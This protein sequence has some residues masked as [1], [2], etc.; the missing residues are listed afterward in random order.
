MPAG[1]E[2]IEQVCFIFTEVDSADA[3][4]LKAAFGA[5]A[6]DV[7]REAGIVDLRGI[8]CAHG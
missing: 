7:G 8:A 1:G 2:P 6:L 3:D 4:L 5:P